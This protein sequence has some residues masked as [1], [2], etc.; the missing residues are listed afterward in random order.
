RRAAFLAR[1]LRHEAS[2]HE[3]SPRAASC[4]KPAAVGAEFLHSL[5]ASGRWLPAL[6]SMSATRETR[7]MKQA[8]EQALVIEV[9][10][11]VVPELGC[12]ELLSAR[13]VCKELRELTSEDHA[14]TGALQALEAA[15]PL[16]GTEGAYMATLIEF[17]PRARG[18]QRDVNSFLPAE[19]ELQHLVLPQRF[20]TRMEAGVRPLPLQFEP[21][22][23]VCDS[24]GS[25]GA[26][27]ALWAHKEQLRE[28]E[29]RVPS[30]AINPRHAESYAQLSTMKYSMLAF[31]RAPMD[32]AGQAKMAAYA[33]WVLDSV[34]EHF[35]QESE[36]EHTE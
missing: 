18:A 29:R 17:P 15:F 32:A 19:P 22:G 14:W 24:Y 5:P 8:R 23:V 20:E 28:P 13:L 25:F 30:W 6:E 36:T 2:F 4:D 3:H 11:L 34:D 35:V 10:P 9:M 21:C 7:L 1:A 12:E 31:F 27:C 26:H 33:S 16:G